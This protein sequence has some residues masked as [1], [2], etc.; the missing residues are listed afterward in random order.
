M[1]ELP[2]LSKIIGVPTYGTLH[3]L[4]NEIK[5][6]TM[7]VHSNIGCGQHVYLVLLVLLTA[8]ALQ[9]KLLLSS[10]TSTKTCH[11]HSDYPPRSRR[12]KI[13][14][15]KKSTGI[16]RNMR[17]GTGANPENCIS[18]KSKIHH[19]HAEQENWPIYRNPLQ[20][21]P[22]SDCNIWENISQPYDLPQTKH[23][24]NELQSTDPD[25]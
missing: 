7:V 13:S 2:N 12:T 21:N 5:P 1:F 11:N 10:S 19:G 4:H 18:S 8:Y 14:V 23:K 9:K 6:N 20:Y 22:I 24:I 16:S 17:S 15:R 25:R 3:L